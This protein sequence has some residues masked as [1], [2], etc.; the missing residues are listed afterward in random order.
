M[1]VKKP[2]DEAAPGQDSFLDIVSNLVG[3]LIIL[4]MVIGMQAK[5]A[6]VQSKTERPTGE[7]A[8]RA[9]EDR[10]ESGRMAIASLTEEL[11]RL[12]GRLRSQQFETAFRRK[13]RDK[14]LLAIA[15]ARSELEEAKTS[16]DDR[17]R[18]Q[19]T[20]VGEISQLRATLEDLTHQESSLKQFERPVEVIKHFPTPLAQTVFGKELHFRLKD[21]RLAVVPLEELVDR[22][23]EDARRKAWKLNDSPSI[24]EVVGPVQ[25]FRLRYTV[26]RTRRTI[27]TDRGPAT[28]QV[29]ELVHFDLLPVEEPLGE[30][31]E[32]ALAMGSAFRQAIE[33]VPSNRAIVTIWVYSDSFAAFRRIKEVLAKERYAVAGRPLPEDRFISGSP[34]GTRSAAQ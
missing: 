9:A 18:E 10:L 28:G 12:G 2:I 7:E 5:Y 15:A 14:V 16:L 20:L 26:R 30:P 33:R 25:G 29:I 11:V 21:N 4:V 34:Q 13:E 1:T 17:Q 6:M 31:V 32:E 8:I 27:N 3:I 23:K 19:V 24:T 22:F